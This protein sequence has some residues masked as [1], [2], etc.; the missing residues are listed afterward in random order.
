MPIITYPRGPRTISRLSPAGH[1]L[2]ALAGLLLWLVLA[3][4]SAGRGPVNAERLPEKGGEGGFD[5]RI[6]GCSPL[7]VVLASRKCPRVTD[8]RVVRR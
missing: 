5:R 1:R 7:C 4:A 6:R 3:I 8:G 2:C